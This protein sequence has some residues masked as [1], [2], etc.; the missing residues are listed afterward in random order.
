MNSFVDVD[1]KFK[2]AL[3]VAQYLAQ[4]LDAGKHMLAKKAS[5][6]EEGIRMFDEEEQSLDLELAKYRYEL[7][8]HSY[9]L[10]SLCKKIADTSIFMFP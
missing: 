6:I 10:S 4:Y 7:D 8:R 2:K 5:V 3:D 9:Y 1:P